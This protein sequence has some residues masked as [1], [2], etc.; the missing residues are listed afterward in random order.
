LASSLADLAHVEC[1][2]VELAAAAGERAL[3]AFRSA[4]SLEFKG[5]KKDNPVTAADREVETFLREELRRTFPDHGLLGE[6][7]ADDIAANAEY[8]WALDPIDGTA[9]FAAGLPLWGVSMG[10]L[11]DGAPVVGCIWVPVGPTL[12]PGVFHARLGGGA[13]FDRQPVRVSEL[14]D[15]R[16]QL[17]A[18][19]G[20]FARAA[21]VSRPASGASRAERILPDWRGLGSC[22]YEQVSIAAG[23]LRAG[24]YLGPSIW[25][26]AAG[27]LIVCQAG[28]VV[29]VWRDHAWGPFDRFE[30]RAPQRGKGPPALRHWAE[31][32]L[33]GAPDAV[34]RISS[35]MSWRPRQPR[36]LRRLLGL[37]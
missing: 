24:L 2:A 6:E 33:V 7:H 11:R 4:L 28:G 16:G 21:R 35:R 31:P 37:G 5:S 3:S 9:N 29:N 30:P 12:G 20:D 32:L 10:L 22:T 36:R 23:S 1:A 26:V 14:A 19:P 34:S 13:C 25:D 27:T 17:M 15:E 8:V 18:V